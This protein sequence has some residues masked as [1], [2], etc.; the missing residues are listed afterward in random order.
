MYLHHDRFWPACNGWSFLLEGPNMDVLPN[1]RER[2]FSILN[3]NDCPSFQHRQ[4]QPSSSP[5]PP[6]NCLTLPPISSITSP[7]FSKF[8]SARPNL[9]RQPQFGRNSSVSSA[10]SPP[11]LRYD[12]TSS[13]SSSK[14]NSSM[15]G[16]PSPITPAYSYNE[17][18]IGPYDSVLRQDLTGNYLPS[19][20]GITPFMDSAMMLAPVSIPQ[21]AFRTKAGSM[22]S[23]PQPIAPAGFPIMPMAADPAQMPTPALSAH[24]SVSS[25]TST[26]QQ[27]QTSPTNASNNTTAKKNKYPCPYAASH[28]CSATFTTSGH[29]A[30]HGKKHTGEKGVH[31]PVCDKA[32]TRKDNMKQHERTHKNHAK[33]GDEKKSKAQATRE[34]VK[35]VQKSQEQNQQAQHP[36]AA[37]IQTQ[38]VPP[39]PAQLRKCS[40]GTS[41]PSDVTLA[42]NPVHTP[43]DI[44]PGFFADTNPQIIMPGDSVMADPSTYPPLSDD[45]LLTEMPASTEKLNNLCIPQPPSLV[46]GFSDLDTLAQAAEASFIDPI[47]P[48]YSQTQF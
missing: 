11:L 21:D 10:G 5:S 35:E 43:V 6:P 16:T 22:V 19:P 1:S 3:N 13:A 25:T 41:E 17:T 24:A 9:L 4:K 18:A 30:R 26:T 42:P 27:S 33:S 36:M 2:V 31:C 34:K 28:N 14:S 20:T 45:A 46:R 48:Y 44:S 15:E 12:S 39:Y 38:S 7:S 32:F 40:S 8:H 47:E 23:Q 29:A 37:T